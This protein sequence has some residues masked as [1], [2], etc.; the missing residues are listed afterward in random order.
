MTMKRKL[1]TGIS[2]MALAML[3]PVS[4]TVSA[5]DMNQEQITRPLPEGS[6][7]GY[8]QTD[9]DRLEIVLNLFR[10]D[11]GSMACSLDSPDQGAEGIPATIDMLSADSVSIQIP[12]IRASFSG[13]VSSGTIFSTISGTFSQAGI[14]SDI[15]FRKGRSILLRPQNPLPPFPYRTEE[16]IFKNGDITF[17]GTLTYPAG[18][19]S[20]DRRKA[21]AVLLVSGSGQQNR[22][23]EIMGHRPF[24]VIA[25]WLAENGIASLRYDDRGTGMS[26]GDALSTTVESNML[27]AAAGLD[28]LRSTGC[29][30]MTGV[31]GH[32]E[33]GTIAFMLASRGKADFI[34]SMAGAA[35]SGIRLLVSQNHIALTRNGIPSEMADRYCTVL[36]KTLEYRKRVYLNDGTDGTPCPGERSPE[37][38]VDSLDRACRT[39]L[40]DMAKANLTTVLATENMWLDSFIATDP[41]IDIKGIMC[42]V[43]AINGSLDTQVNAS[44]NLGR[45]KELL[46]AVNTCSIREYKGLNHLFQHCRT[47]SVSEYRNIIETISKEVLCDITEWIKS[48]D[49]EI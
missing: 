33:G 36:E 43:F 48:L 49:N 39:S 44:E 10:M 31:I 25:D 18:Y 4:G 42:P 47:G 16:V 12:A 27:D 41:A 38:I 34:V 14:D 13:K 3:C 19:D 6:W 9:Q 1:T 17:S 30:S 2:A 29:F 23:E 20:T 8:L 26:G 21:P 15:E 40:D 7:S 32:S 22:D 35:V 11:D 46:P 28:Y 24:A 45:L 5:Q 37:E